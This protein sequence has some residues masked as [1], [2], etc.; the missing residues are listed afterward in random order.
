MKLSDEYIF[1]LWQLFVAP[2]ASSFDQVHYDKQVKEL[3]ES[4]TYEEFDAILDFLFDAPEFIKIQETKLEL[5]PDLHPLRHELASELLPGVYNK[6]YTSDVRYFDIVS[7]KIIQN[8]NSEY[9]YDFL[10]YVDDM[11]QLQIL[12]SVFDIAPNQRVNILNSIDGL[13]MGYV[14]NYPQVA[15][16]YLEAR[17]ADFSGHPLY[18]EIRNIIIRN[19]SCLKNNT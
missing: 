11:N 4:V 9:L 17:L 6:C 3:I 12:V 1:D 13:V 14:E 19:V 7:K 10:S 8:F 16:K 18:S 5:I 15:E 2:D